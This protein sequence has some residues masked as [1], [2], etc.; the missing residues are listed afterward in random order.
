MKNRI[1]AVL[2]LL[3]AFAAPA[4]A[5]EMPQIED[6]ACRSI[7]LRAA[8]DLMMHQIQLDQSDNGDGTYDFSPEYALVKDALSDADYTIA[9]LE[10]TVGKNPIPYSGFPH[11][12]APEELLQAIRDAGVD[13]L[14]LANNHMLDRY[15]DGMKLTV[16]CVEKY[17][18]DHSGAYRT[19]EEAQ[20]TC[21]VDVNGFRLGF[22]CYTAHT[23][24]LENW[25]DRKATDFG[26]DYLAKA[27]IEDDVRALKEDGAQ[28][29][30][31]IPHWGTEYRRSPDPEVRKYAQ[32]MIAAGVDVIL[33]SHPHMV[34]PV[35]WLTVETET[36][37]R[38]GLVAWSL[39]NFVD[40]MSMQ[41]TDAGI[42]LDFTI[43]DR[44]DGSFRV[45]EAGYIPVYCW[46][47]NDVI[48]AVCS[49]DYLD[50]RPE[51]MGDA[52]YARM[53]ESRREIVSLIGDGFKLLDH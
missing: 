18:F 14:T 3:C 4:F 30:I 44:G 11:F 45:T 7:R 51:G 49:G 9:N 22:L 33:G 17:G 16:D 27:N 19:P 29:I 23:N 39:G 1:I 8:G 26:M 36:G 2:L 15:F 34:Q 38:T 52:A 28:A 20:E 35:E 37:S 48:Q 10:T 32:R 6:V 25:S 47:R 21:V 5:E 46:R 12:N 13:F 40:N 50:E 53:K 43:V 31:A 41:Y 24:G 42:I